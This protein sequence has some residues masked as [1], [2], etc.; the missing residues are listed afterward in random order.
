MYNY[1]KS[2]PKDNHDRSSRTKYPDPREPRR[3][4]GAQPWVPGGTQTTA[5]L[6][7]AGV[8]AE[9]SLLL[10][11]LLPFHLILAFLLPFVFFLLEVGITHKGGNSPSSVCAL[12]RKLGCKMQ[13]S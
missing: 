11:P 8:P 1:G 7:A 12:C 3:S 13:Q 4:W 10:C 6:P 5:P 9:L 2:G